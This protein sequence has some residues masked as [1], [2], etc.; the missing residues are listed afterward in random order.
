MSLELLIEKYGYVALFV[1]AVLEGETAVVLAGFAA[2]R[3]LLK[4]PQVMT[5]AFLSTLLVDQSAFFLGK[6]YGRDFLARRL[7]WKN[8]VDRIHRYLNRHQNLAIIGFR[9]LY[10]MR[11]AATFALGTSGVKPLRFV[12]LNIISVFCLA[13]LFTSGGYIFGRALA[14]L[15]GDIQRYQFKIMLGLIILALVVYLFRL[16]RKSKGPNETSSK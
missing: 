14:L 16:L 2:N 5:I 11:I 8:Y 10:G 7:N 13:V 3:G 6:Y 1:G 15:T 12:S 9:F 4:L